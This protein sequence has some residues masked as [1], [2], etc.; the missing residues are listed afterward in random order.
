MLRG[1]TDTSK[2]SFGPIEFAANWQF[3]SFELTNY[4]LKKGPFFTPKELIATNIVSMVY[5]KTNEKVSV[6][7]FGP[8]QLAKS[9]FAALYPTILSTKS[10][11]KTQK[12]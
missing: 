6:S 2:K 4:A 1:W 11:M 10:L 5:F 12:E 9:Y 8:K 3:F 7:H